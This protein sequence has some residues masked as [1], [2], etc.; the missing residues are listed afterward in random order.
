VIDEFWI[1]V[2]S[3]AVFAVMWAKGLV[4]GFRVDG[5]SVKNHREVRII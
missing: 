2:N 1:I 5:S 4:N 3:D